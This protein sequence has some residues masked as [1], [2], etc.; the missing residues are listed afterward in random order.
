MKTGWINIENYLRSP[1]SSGKKH[2]FILAIRSRFSKIFCVVRFL[3]NSPCDFA[4]CQKCASLSVYNQILPLRVFSVFKKKPIWH[5]VWG[6]LG[7][8]TVRWI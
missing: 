6:R 8:E 7:S 2:D 3:R 1:P 4:N 5:D